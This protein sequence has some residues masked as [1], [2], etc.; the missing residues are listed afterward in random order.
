MFIFV[1]YRCTRLNRLGLTP[2]VLQKAGPNT[3]AVRA[4]NWSESAHRFIKLCVSAGNI[5]AL[6]M[7]GMVSQLV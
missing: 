5:E 3:L 2:V 6:Y 7:L 1:C 4:K